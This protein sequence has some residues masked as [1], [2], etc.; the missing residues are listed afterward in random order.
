MSRPMKF[1]HALTMFHIMSYIVEKNKIIGYFLDSSLNE[2]LKN[3]YLLNYN[4]YI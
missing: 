2:F 1:I 3:S 4:I